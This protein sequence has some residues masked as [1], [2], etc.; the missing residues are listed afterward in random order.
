MKLLTF[1]SLFTLFFF[2]A[3]SRSG[4]TAEF[5]ILGAGKISCRVV[6]KNPEDKGLRKFYQNW[7]QG[8]ITAT[9]YFGA[10]IRAGMKTRTQD[11]SMENH[12]LPSNIAPRPDVIWYKILSYCSEDPK[13]SL[14]DAVQDLLKSQWLKAKK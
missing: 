9:N 5:N 1:V 3:N 13:A 11:A 12:P 14:S 6:L 7:A 8:W 4:E 2:L 10:P